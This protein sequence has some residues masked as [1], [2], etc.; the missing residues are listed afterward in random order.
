[1]AQPAKEKATVTE[2]IKKMPAPHTA[3]AAG[4]QAKRTGRKSKATIFTGHKFRWI[5]QV[6]RDCR[7]LPALGAAVAAEF[8]HYFDLA[9]GGAA[10]PWQGAIADALG[11]R[12]EAVNRVINALI[13][14][15]HLTSTRGGRNK[16]NVYHFVLKD[17]AP[18][19]AQPRTS[20]PS[21][22]CADDVRERR[23]RCA[24]PRTESSSKTPETA[25]A[26]SQ[27][28]GRGRSLTLADP[29]AG[30]GAA[31]TA[32]APKRVEASKQEIIPPPSRVPSLNH[33]RHWRELRAVWAR[34]AAFLDDQRADRAAFDWACREVAPEEILDAARTHVAAA[35][36]PRFLKRLAVWLD[37]RGWETVPP[38]K[39][40]K[41]RR[42]NRYGKPD[43]MAFCLAEGGYVENADGEMIWPYADG[44]DDAISG[45]V[46]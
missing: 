32:A 42:Q 30:G 15:G 24:Q 18:G 21:K 46:S 13:E 1:V 7:N 14:R 9:H 4:P 10:W 31:L 5:E 19:C 40:A 29:P 33:E 35:D 26:V 22:M 41:R 20:S 39:R 23:F 6:A 25:Y 28:R 44:E 12:R 17:K 11:V 43:M 27:E 8:C 38:P 37:A 3:A 34:P 2:R 16:P 45:V 36:A